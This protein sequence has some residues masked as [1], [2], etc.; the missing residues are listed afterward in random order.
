MLSCIGPCFFGGG[1]PHRGYLVAWSFLRPGPRQ[2]TSWRW[3]SLRNQ[4]SRN[5]SLCTIQ[6]QGARTPGTSTCSL[7]GIFN[8]AFRGD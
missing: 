8:G 7:R 1:P 2:Q 3:A 4:F 6:N 5:L